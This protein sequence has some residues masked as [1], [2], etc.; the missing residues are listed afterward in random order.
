MSIGS[1]YTCYVC[2][3]TFSR[4]RTD[5]EALDEGLYKWPECE[6]SDMEIVCDDCYKAFTRWYGEQSAEEKR[7]MKD[8]MI[9]ERVEQ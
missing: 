2:K 5:E 8:K 3:E 6:V 9:A 4:I 7:H 1:D